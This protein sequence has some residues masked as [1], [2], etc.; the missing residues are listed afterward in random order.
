MWTFSVPLC[1]PTKWPNKQGKKIT[2]LLHHLYIVFYTHHWHNNNF[3]QKH[4]KKTINKWIEYQGFEWNSALWNMSPTINGPFDVSDWDLQS[5]VDL[6]QNCLQLLLLGYLRL[7]HLSHIQPLTLQLL[8]NSKIN[9]YVLLS[10]TM[11]TQGGPSN[12]IGIR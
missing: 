2:T 6:L 8:C 9:T 11:R 12:P 1:H 4:S 5:V 10:H 3:D 7:G